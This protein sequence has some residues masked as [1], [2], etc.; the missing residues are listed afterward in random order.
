[1][2]LNIRYGYGREVQKL[3]S[4]FRKKFLIDVMYNGMLI[5]E[6]SEYTN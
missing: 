3:M 1:M 2:K 4:K 5:G 6:L